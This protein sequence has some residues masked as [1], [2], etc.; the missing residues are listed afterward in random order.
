MRSV[1]HSIFI[2]FFSLSF[3]IPGRAH[4]QTA[5][6]YPSIPLTKAPLNGA[7]NPHPDSWPSLLGDDG[8]FSKIFSSPQS[9]VFGPTFFNPESGPAVT[10]NGVVIPGH[11]LDSQAPINVTP[12]TDGSGACLIELANFFSQNFDFQNGRFARSACFA[13]A[14][15]DTLMCAPSDI[16]PACVSCRRS[17][18]ECLLKSIPESCKNVG[19]PVLVTNGAQDPQDQLLED[20]WP[21]FPD[22]LVAGLIPDPVDSVFP[23][24]S[25][26]TDF[27]LPIDGKEIISANPPSRQVAALNYL[28]LRSDFL[29]ILFRRINQVNTEDDFNDFLAQ[30]VPMPFPG[31]LL[32]PELQQ[33]QAPL[34]GVMHDFNGGVQTTY[35]FQNECVVDRVKSTQNCRSA[36][37]SLETVPLSSSESKDLVILHQYF[38]D[39]ISL[40]RPTGTL[41]TSVANLRN[42]SFLRQFA[43]LLFPRDVPG[44]LAEKYCTNV[45]GGNFPGKVSGN[46]WSQPINVSFFSQDYDFVQA[47]SLGHTSG[48]VPVRNSILGYLTSYKN[49]GGAEF[50]R[51]GRASNTNDPLRF[52]VGKTPTHVEKAN[53]DGDISPDLV[54]SNF[55]GFNLNGPLQPGLVGPNKFL[56]TAGGMSFIRNFDGKSGELL[57]LPL[58]PH[59]GAT[60]P[61]HPIHVSCGDLNGDGADDCLVTFMDGMGI[62]LDM[63]FVKEYRV[64]DVIRSDLT[65]GGDHL[66]PDMGGNCLNCSAPPNNLQLPS[67]VTEAIYGNIPNFN[68][69]DWA[70]QRILPLV[71]PANPGEVQA[72]PSPYDLYECSGSAKD[73]TCPDFSRSHADR[74]VYKVKYRVYDPAGCGA[75]AP[76]F[77]SLV[78]GGQFPPPAWNCDTIQ[79]DSVMSTASFTCH[80][81]GMDASDPWKCE[82]AMRPAPFAGVPSDCNIRCSGTMPAQA[83]PTFPQILDVVISNGPTPF[84]RRGG[85]VEREA[86][87]QC[88]Y[89]FNV[90]RN[91]EFAVYMND[92]HGGFSNATSSLQLQYVSM[93]GAA[94][95][96]RADDRRIV[97]QFPVA[98]TSMT[99]WVVFSS[100]GNSIPADRIPRMS[101]RSSLTA[102]GRG[103]NGSMELGVWPFHSVLADMVD[104][105]G[106]PNPDG[107]K[108]AI[109]ALNN[110]HFVAILPSQGGRTPF[111][112]SPT[113][114]IDSSTP[115]YKK[116]LS[117]FLSGPLQ[118][119]NNPTPIS[120]SDQL[121]LLL[122]LA[123]GTNF[124]SV[125]QDPINGLNEL[126][127]PETNRGI[128]ALHGFPWRMLMTWVNSLEYPKQ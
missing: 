49:K 77:Q 104:K 105:T 123:S 85:P 109:I 44:A 117:D 128:V 124:V 45:I 51:I 62:H 127:A 83:T 42:N 112:G 65:L 26:R 53:L 115:K 39:P 7:A 116:E 107:L 11:Y 126:S 4:G 63:N 121:S 75:A 114:F 86:I 111:N 17:I 76:E 48:S 67:G 72:S 47:G 32:D 25:Q 22:T 95:A 35:N 89:P 41:P 52:C 19:N 98:Y 27:F 100:T 20:N 106:A 31:F 108:D 13:S 15:C 68:D 23:T 58:V 24:L 8:S 6:F 33:Q 84:F 92:G 28:P 90:D 3:L 43:Q 81:P 93:E 66:V 69:G 78:S 30:F 122:G 80:V 1:K 74:F 120:S 18:L 21:A 103:A 38:L 57:H 54:V 79:Q 96:G 73:I 40:D 71:N 118:H 102:Q 119:A 59:R 10:S 101:L 16:S 70:C 50:E 88:G 46:P 91:S 34:F 60:H 94:N 2:L 110:S 113:L 125:P 14:F 9:V 37:V 97:S 64:P 55:G 5:A 99:D 56:E 82:Y 29:N 87:Y 12:Q 36:P 61:L